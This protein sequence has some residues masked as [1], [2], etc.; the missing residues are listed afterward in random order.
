MLSAIR[1]AETAYENKEV[2]VGA[3]IT[4]NK[5]IIGKGYNQIEMLK[6][7][8]AHAEI[9]AITAASASL[10]N[11]SLS[12]CEMYVTLEPC[13]MC[14]GAAILAKIDSIF[15]ASFDPKSGACGSVY[16]IP[17]DNK[18]NHKIEIYSGICEDISKD[19]LKRFFEE[20]RGNN[21]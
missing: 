12:G 1:L 8:T 21:N 18:L 7:N 9:L 11:K 20:I 2:P 13:I 10:Q 6:D 17:E 4:C 14:V 16:N 5:K 3:V 15:F 19:L